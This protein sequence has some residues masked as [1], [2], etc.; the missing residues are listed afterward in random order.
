MHA[1]TVPEGEEKKDG[2]ENVLKETMAKNSPNLAKDT[3][4]E[5]K[6]LNG[7]K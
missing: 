1:I 7:L 2:A 4:L 6:K 3:N 5:N